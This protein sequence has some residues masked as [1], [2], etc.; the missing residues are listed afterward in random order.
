MCQENEVILFCFPPYTMH[1]LQPLDVVVF[2]SL[3]DKFS[4]AV[5]ALSFSK[6]NFIVSKR[7][8]A[9]VFKHTFEQ[10]FSITNI[11]AGFSKSGIF[12]F[13]PDAVATAKTVPSTLYGSPLY[14]SSAAS[15]PRSSNSSDAQSSMKSIPCQ[16]SSSDSV[17]SHSENGCDT[18]YTP[19]SPS[20]IVSPLCSQ[21]TEDSGM[22]TSSQPRSAVPYCQSSCCCRIGA[23]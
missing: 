9:R 23:T 8:F 3:K 6:L 7:D 17:S 20:P 18:T 16:P 10:A 11:K 12:P 22:H 15:D 14:L 5:R 13:N 1:A 4:K 21:N 19:V 2:K